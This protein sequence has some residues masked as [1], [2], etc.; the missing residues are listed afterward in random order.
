MLNRTLRRWLGIAG[1]LLAGLPTVN[2]ADDPPVIA[3]IVANNAPIQTIDKN[4]L[5][6]VFLRK[7]L[8]WPNRQTIR[9]VNLSSTHPL[10]RVFSERIVGL[11]PEDLENYW[12]DQYFHGTFPPYSVASEEAALRYVAES[13]SAIGYVSACAVD[14]RVKVLLY[15]T[16]SGPMAGGNSN[17]FCPQH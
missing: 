14:E 2:S 4:T 5:A 7:M 3:V 1:L 15:I 8:L 11:A 10:R 17:R 16:A 13:T 6:R 12:N 9:P